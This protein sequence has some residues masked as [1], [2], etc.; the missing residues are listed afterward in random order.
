MH[1]LLR[2]TKTS[3]KVLV[4]WF[5]CAYRTALDWKSLLA[6]SSSPFCN[7]FMKQSLHVITVLL[8]LILYG[9]EFMNQPNVLLS[10]S[11]VAALTSH[12]RSSVVFRKLL[13]YL[14]Y[15]NIQLIQQLFCMFTWVSQ[16][17]AKMSK[18][19][20]WNQ[21]SNVQIFSET[22]TKGSECGSQVMNWDKAL[23][24]HWRHKVR[25]P[26]NNAVMCISSPTL[27]TKL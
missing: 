24:S 12:Y 26:A 21:D 16:L 25:H 17:P 7:L 8:W 14:I 18:K 27:Q 13:T 2:L 19:S 6:A 1:C 20:K 11:L 22:I 9:F 4:F 5:E 23:V 10:T 15:T 3:G